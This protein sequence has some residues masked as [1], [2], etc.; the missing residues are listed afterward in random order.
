MAPFTTTF[1]ASEL[2]ARVQA[3]A[4]GRKRKLPGGGDVIL[5]ECELL[6]MVQYDCLIDNPDS[7]SSVV[8]CHQIR[9][10]FRR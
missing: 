8:H 1:P 6:S 4:S 10:W 7:P 2:P 5:A 9:R 3:D